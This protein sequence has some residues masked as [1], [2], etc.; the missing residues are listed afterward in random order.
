MDDEPGI[1]RVEAAILERIGYT[2]TSHTSSI[3]ALEAFRGQPQEFD[4]VITDYSMPKMAGDQMALELLKINP[5][6]KIILCTG[7]SDDIT[8][9]TAEQQGIRTI[10]TKPVAKKD[11]AQKIK[12]ILEDPAED[13]G[14][15]A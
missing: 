4:L 9:E 11:L 5:D 10:L 14:K 8:K 3:K 6:T 1:I 13:G 15:M 2:V 12:D 7:F